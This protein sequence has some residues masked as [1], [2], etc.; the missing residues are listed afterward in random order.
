MK[1]C[2]IGT[3]YVG[4]VTGTCLSDFGNTVYCIDKDQ[5]K[6]KNLKKGVIDFYELGLKEMVLRNQEKERLFFFSDY[7]KGLKNVEIIF[8]AVGTPPLEN[9]Q[10]DL[11]H[12]KQ[13]LEE[14]A[15]YFKKIKFKSPKI[16]AIKSTVPIGTCEYV[17]NFL[18]EHE[19]N[20]NLFV[21][22]NPEFLREGK[23]VLDF[24]HPD[25]I[26]IGTNNEQAVKIMT[27]LY[28]PLNNKLIFMD[29][30]S[31]E[32]VKYASN[33]FLA[34]RISLINELAN[35]CEKV[36]ADIKKVAE[37]AGHDNRIGHSY[38]KAGIGYGGSCLP[39][40]IKALIHLAE[41]KQ[42]EPIL[43]KSIDLINQ[44]QRKFFK[45][46]II[47]I[48]GD[49]EGKIIGIWGLSF[50]PQTD[51]LRDAPS[52][53]II[54]YLLKSGAKIKAY[55]PMTNE[56][57]KKFLPDIEYVKNPY[58]AIENTDATILITEWNEFREIDFTKFKNKV[59]KP[60]IFDG[61]NV[62]DP[63]YLKKIG[64][65]YYAMGTK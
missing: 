36:G 64:I 33:I 2:V 48:L 47:S 29:Q 13:T 30:K 37:G 63:N 45:N 49:L 8:I 26:V 56:K 50:K 25:R 24:L 3:G 1:I 60:I 23:A 41:E 61:R 38:L 22:S 57:A 32:M 51:D 65:D 35:I 58:L 42:Y 39:K 18:K 44:R 43:L 28:K 52:I 21:V 6:V 59:K 15:V 62:F 14:L 17:E 5:N 19:L 11:S 40:D 54:K 20:K 27:E 34:S 31:S 12:L 16:I 10:A 53:P 7:E 46:K 9:G 4:L 55:D